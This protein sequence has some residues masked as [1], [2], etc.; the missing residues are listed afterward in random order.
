MNPD[1]PKKQ[2]SEADRKKAIKVKDVDMY[3]MNHKQR[4]T[5]KVMLSERYMVI[6]ALN[7]RRYIFLEEIQAASEIIS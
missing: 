5:D 3:V 6:T 2:L 1:A 7:G 4:F